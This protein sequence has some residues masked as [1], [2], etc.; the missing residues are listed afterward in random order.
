MI[1]PDL[2]EWRR[3]NIP[4]WRRVLKESIEAGDKGREK[5]AQWILKSVLEDIDDRPS[6]MLKVAKAIAPAYEAQVGIR[7]EEKAPNPQPEL[8]Q[9]I[10]QISLF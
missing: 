3:F 8:V 2:I 7:K 10:G 9:K 1:G 6:M 4:C 5:Y